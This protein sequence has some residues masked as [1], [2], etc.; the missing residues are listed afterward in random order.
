M[1]L[2]LTA[3]AFSSKLTD[4]RESAEQVCPHLS[5]VSPRVVHSVPPLLLPPNLLR[6][7]AAFSSVSDVSRRFSVVQIRTYIHR[8]IIILASSMD[9]DI[10]ESSLA[11]A[12]CTGGASVLHPCTCN[13]PRHR[14]RT[15]CPMLR[16]SDTGMRVEYPVHA[17]LSYIYGRRERY[18]MVNVSPSIRPMQAKLPAA[19]LVALRPASGECGLQVNASNTLDAIRLR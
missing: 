18:S 2:F 16:H 5:K 17:Q 11:C 12:F 8:P 4:C 1:R 6:Y 14:A 19:F 13:L 15:L 9:H 3:T 7:I 10:H